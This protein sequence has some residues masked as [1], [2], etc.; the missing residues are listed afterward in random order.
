MLN[1]CRF[2][3]TVV[4]VCQTRQGASKLTERS[5]VYIGYDVMTNKQQARAR[6]FTNV[7]LERSLPPTGAQ[8][9]YDIV[10]DNLGRGDLPI[11]FLNG[12]LPPLVY[13][14]SVDPEVGIPVVNFQDFLAF[15]ICL[16]WNGWDGCFN[17]LRGQWN[18]E[19]AHKLFWS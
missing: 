17:Y 3:S 9:D 12:S 6:R 10:Q 15:S 18:C 8:V 19:Q 14:N 11:S 13:L 4:A 7:Y 1:S 2:E 5:A 16:P